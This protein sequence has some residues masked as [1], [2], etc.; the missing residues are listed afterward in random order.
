MKLENKIVRVPLGEIKP[1]PFNPRKTFDETSLKELASTIKA[2]G[3]QVP[4]NSSR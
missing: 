2:E 4:S 1:S 3:I